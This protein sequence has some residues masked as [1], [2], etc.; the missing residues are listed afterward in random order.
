MLAIANA[1][2]PH[3]SCIMFPFAATGGLGHSR[4]FGG[5]GLEIEVKGLGWARD[6]TLSVSG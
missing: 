1:K 4:K 2:S 6:T 3:G 5:W